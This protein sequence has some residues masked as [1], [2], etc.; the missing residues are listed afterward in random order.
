MKPFIKLAIINI[1]VFILLVFIFN[2]ISFLLIDSFLFSSSKKEYSGQSRYKL[3]S[4]SK[5][6]E[7]NK[8][9]FKEFYQLETDYIPYLVWSRKEF[10]GQTTK[11]NSLGDRVTP[12]FD[13]Q[14]QDSTTITRFFGGSTMW[15]TGVDNHGTIPFF[16]NSM[17]KNEVVYNHGESG[18]VSRQNLARLINLIN[19]D[20]K[21][22]KVIFYDG[23][24]DITELC[25]VDVSINSHNI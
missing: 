15:G 7:Y 17:N 19:Q 3:L 5:T 1:I 21:A 25:R 14:N 4:N 20:E 18:F 24:N 10:N 6:E 2:V 12:C 11:I 8:L 13:C 9:V 16:Y 23:W 22:N